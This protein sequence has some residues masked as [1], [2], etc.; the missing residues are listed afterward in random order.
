M[1]KGKSV[2]VTGGAKGIGRYTAKTFA[3]Q[4]ARV[5][6]ADIE[7]ARLDQTL[8]ELAELGGEAMAVPTD[9]RDEEQVRTL[10]ADVAERFGG[11][12][13][14]VN[15]AGI[16]PHFMWGT[17]RWPKVQDMDREFWVKVLSTNLGGTFLC[18]KHAVPYLE[19]QG[20]GHI[21]N[22]H[23]GGGKT[24]A[25]ALA[26]VVTK[27][28]IVTFTEWHAEEVR[29]AGI[30]VVVISPGAAIATEDA[31]QEARDRMPGPEFAGER[32]TLAAQVPM[33][34]S[35]HLLDLQDG[36]LVILK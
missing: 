21:V 23:G 17:P 1:L 26:Y 16:V 12:D 10:M 7:E 32:F 34:M 3:A 18:S 30:C 19:K 13:V 2:I 15:N 5:A 35:G 11:I 20:G 29:D 33:E 9:V 22:L 31:P 28:S 24:P 8:A 14:L 4:G 25:G 27:E 6:I 36:E